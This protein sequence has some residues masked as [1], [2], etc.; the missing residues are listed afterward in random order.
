M[1]ALL[2]LSSKIAPGMEAVGYGCVGGCESGEMK[3]K[4]DKKKFKH[5]K[6]LGRER[7]W[8]SV[9]HGSCLDKHFLHD[10]YVTIPA[11]M[12]HMDTFCDFDIFAAYYI[13]LI[14]H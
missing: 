10:Y 12:S 3:Q 4:L 6:D 13:T 1:Q 7:P 8:K 11:V 2:F 5:R 9:K 14:S